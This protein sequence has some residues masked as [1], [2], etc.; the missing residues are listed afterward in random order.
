M[1]QTRQSSV[2]YIAVYIN[3]LIYNLIYILIY[4]LIYYLYNLIYN[5]ICNL[6]WFEQTLELDRLEP[7]GPINPSQTQHSQMVNT[8]C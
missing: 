3:N 6:I 8:V 7:L 4:N 2:V 5:L 1:E